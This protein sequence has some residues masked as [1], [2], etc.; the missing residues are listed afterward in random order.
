MD[1]NQLVKNVLL[2]PWRGKQGGKTSREWMDDVKEWCPADV[3]TLSMHDAGP[4]RMEENC[5]GSIGH[6]RGLKKK[7]K[8]RYSAL[9]KYAGLV[10]CSSV[11]VK[12]LE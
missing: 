10:E 9:R 8:S 7:K 2:E 1:D 11:A 12:A 4:I 3:H 5:Q 6:Q